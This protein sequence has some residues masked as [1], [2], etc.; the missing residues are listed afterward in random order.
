MLDAWND[1]TDVRPQIVVTDIGEYVNQQCCERSFKLRLNKA[2]IARRYPFY[3][4]VRSPLNPI[5]ALVGK[6]REDALGRKLAEG[7][8]FLNPEWKDDEENHLPWEQFLELLDD[9]EAGRECFAR[10]V[11]IAGPVGE[12]VLSGRMDFVVLHWKDQR[13]HLR[14]VECKASRKDRTY[15]RIQLAA[16]RTM[17]QDILRRDGLRIGGKR[18][19]DVVLESVVARIDDDS[20]D[21]QDAMSLPSLELKEEVD[22]LRSLLSSGGPLQHIAGTDLDTLGYRLD[23]KCDACDHCPVCLPESARQ[24]RLELLGIDQSVVRILRAAEVQRLDDLADLDPSSDVAKRLRSTVGFNADLDDLITRA[25]AR[26]STLSEKRDGDWGVMSKRHPGPGL[27]PNHEDPSGNCLVRVFLDVEY[28]YIED[29]VV[30]LAAHVTDSDTLLLTRTAWD[31]R[32]PN[33]DPEVVERAPKED[34]FGPLR[35]EEVVRFIEEPW[36]GDPQRDDGVEERLLRSFFDDLVRAVRSVGRDEERPLHFYVWSQGD[37]RHLIDAC[38]RAGGPLLHNLT[39]LLGCRAECRG[40]LE[41]MIFSPLR[42]EVEQKVM[43]GYTGSSLAIATSLTWFGY[44]RFH[45]TRLVS[46]APVDLSR[47]FERDVFDFRASLYLNGRGEWCDRSDPGARREYHEIRTRFSSDLNAPYWHAMWGTLPEVRSRDNMLPKAMADYRRGGTRELISAFMSAKCQALRWLEERLF[48]NGTISKPPVP[49]RDLGTIEQRFSSRYSLV[50]ACLGFLRLDHYVKKTE[51]LAECVRSPSARVAEGSCLPLKDMFSFVEEPDRTYVGGVLDLERFSLDPSTFFSTCTIEEG[52]FVRISPYSGDAYEGQRIGDVLYQGV[53]AKVEVLNPE[54]GA[55]KAGVIP[56]RSKDAIKRRYLPPSIPEKAEGMTIALAG[57]SLANFARARVDAW[58]SSH[59]SVNAA[60]W[61]DPQAPAV[62]VKE[63]VSK[64]RLLEFKEVLRDVK[65]QDK[66]LDEVQVQACLDGLESTVQLLLGPP[67]TGKTNTTAAA[68]LV[69]LAARPN[70][71]LFFLSA[72]THTAVDGLTERIRD[73]LP[74]FRRAA[75]EHG[76]EYNLVKV[77]RLTGDLPS[78]ELISTWDDR[79]VRE[80]LKHGDVVLCGS[81]NEVLKIAEKLSEGEGLKA[82]GLIIDEASMLVFPDFLA[83]AT[84]VSEDGEIMLAGDHMQLAPITAHEWEEETREQVVRLAP[85]ES[86]YQ[87]VRRLCAK[88]PP[89]AVR[90]SALTITYRL[91]P[92]LTHLISGVYRGEGVALRS[93]KGQDD[94]KGN[95]TSLGD[96]WAS[97]GVYLVVHDEGES[98]KSNGFEARLIRDILN[99]RGVAES[100]VPPG[101]VSIITPHRAQRGVLKN[102]LMSD[103][104]YH[105]KLIDTVERLQGGECETII[106]SGTQSDIGAISGNAEFILD[107][108]RT[109]VIFSRAKER[110]IVVCSRN[111]MDSMPADIDDYRSSWLWKHLRSVCDTVALRVD[112][113]EHG[114]EVRVPGAYWKSVLSQ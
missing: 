2:E 10:E 14:I 106:V 25:K 37:M 35:G 103:F 65:L 8:R 71:K 36:S 17:V 88:C 26:R 73:V 16:Y 34:R 42:E 68:V 18:F 50:S 77:L 31:N 101:T 54:L 83:L 104:E 72:N 57:E 92:E 69:R 24:R 39:E 67:G 93:V 56:S 52:S 9:T 97:G 110:L 105:I 40:D 44:P 21:V 43:L 81:V 20:N 19:D 46:G 84:L 99:A 29:R 91:T 51:W 47:V 87:A 113:Y 82:D 27:L 59:G 108:N 58:L 64:V 38:S 70:N 96:L 102:L 23:A 32:T 79:R 41:Q 100:D 107:R 6:E 62:P 112:G 111:L 7:M 76:L 4:L 11:E 74:Y 3:P 86:C 114:V 94:K 15:H 109:N 75:D 95:I 12:F 28:D 53:T 98:R 5:L 85:H 55:F 60:R 49:L 90:Q 80:E 78:E 1:K 48:K 66:G 33:F 63:A 22:D 13:P 89:G 45:W 61:F 30:G